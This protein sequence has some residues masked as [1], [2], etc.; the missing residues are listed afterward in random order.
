MFE[1]H[2]L[3]DPKCEVPFVDS[4]SYCAI[5]FIGPGKG[6][7]ADPNN[8]A[9]DIVFWEGFICDRVVV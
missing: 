9:I 2:L 3:V 5:I 8:I 4:R 6:G 1:N 7:I